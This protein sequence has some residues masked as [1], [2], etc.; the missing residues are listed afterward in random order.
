MTLSP[1]KHACLV[2][3]KSTGPKDKPCHPG[4]GQVL[5]TC[6]KV[7]CRLPGRA[8]AGES[9]Q[10]CAQDSDKVCPR[11][12]RAA[13]GGG[14]SQKDA[15]LVGKGEPL[16]APCCG[17]WGSPPQRRVQDHPHAPS[18][19]VPGPRTALYCPSPFIHPPVPQFPLSC[20]GAERA[21]EAEAGWVAGDRGAEGTARGS[22]SR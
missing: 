5:F 20:E 14:W 21:E 19:R 22:L 9:V 16:P 8:S 6:P 15:Q 10:L 11:E 2:M 13:P 12:G 4:P 3:P 7:R 18:L 17:P 1:R